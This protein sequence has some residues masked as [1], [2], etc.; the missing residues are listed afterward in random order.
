MVHRHRGPIARKC[1]PRRESGVGTPLACLA[2]VPAS[3]PARV[4]VVDDEA[5]IREA[6]GE[7]LALEGYVVAY[8]ETAVRALA[9]VRTDPPDVV[10]LDLAM[11]GAV[12]GESV[13]A[14]ISTVAPVIVITATIDVELARRT[15]QEGAFDFVMKPFNL[16]RVGEIVT[17]AL[18]FG[19]R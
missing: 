12:G 8:A 19:G 6:L 13:V 4:L 1:P 2:P 10:L 14:A 5:Q 11:P 7:Y 15:L 3:R 9:M 16:R 17:A 18:A